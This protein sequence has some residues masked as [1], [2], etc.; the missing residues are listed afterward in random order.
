M[1]LHEHQAKEI[2]RRYGIAVPPGHVAETPDQAADSFS[3]LAVPLAA[4]KAQIHAGGRGKGVVM[5]DDFRAARLR[6]GVQLARSAAEAG[7]AAGKMLGH[8]LVTRQT[9]PRGRVVRRVLVEAACGIHRELY[10]GIALDRRAGRPVFMASVRG[11]VEVEEVAAQDPQA[12]LREPFDVD[13]GLQA[14]QARLLG[15]ELGLAGEASRQF[16]RLAPA[17]GRLYVERDC[18]LAEINPLAVSQTGDL[19]ALDA[20]MSIDDRALFR[21]PEI[22]ALRDETEEDPAERAAARAG[23]SYVAMDG[24]VGCMVNGAGLAMATMD[25]LALSGGAPANFLDVGGGA[26]RDQVR[27]AFRLLLANPAVKS[28]FVNIFGGILRCDVLAAGIVEAVKEV[29]VK[30]PVVVRGEAAGAEAGREILKGSGLRIVPASDM[31]DGARKAIEAA[32]GGA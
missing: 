15:F 31:A 29:E 12:L 8:P 9:G 2:L 3:R 27:E 24:R 20:K 25:V 21:Q 14:F 26:S 4:V 18:T 28:V 7:E 32:G 6:G 5:E 13:G 1:N 16:A 19:L 10:L 23:F 17:L 30:V 22:E 11:G